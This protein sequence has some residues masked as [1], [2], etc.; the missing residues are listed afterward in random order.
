L[1]AYVEDSRDID[2]IAIINRRLLEGEAGILAEIHRTIASTYSKSEMDG[3]YMMWTDIGKLEAADMNYPYYNGGQLSYGA[4]FN[5]ITWWILKK[6]GISIIGPQPTALHFEIG[7]QHLVEYVV[8]NMNTYWARR[9]EMIE[10]AMENKLQFTTKEIDIEI[11][12]SILGLLRQYYTLKEHG[13]VSKLGA[14]EYALLHM[15]KEWHSVIQEAIDI[16]KCIVRGCC[17]YDNTI[18]IL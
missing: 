14:G 4:H 5:A 3:V 7:P 8:G 18:N 11:E 13:I 15:P 6:H 17:C 12:W 1:D 2:F 9:I 16:R 10:Q